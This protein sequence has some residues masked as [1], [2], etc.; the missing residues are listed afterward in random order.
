VPASV[1]TDPAWWAREKVSLYDCLPKVFAPSA[2]LAEQGVAVAQGGTFAYQLMPGEVIVVSVDDINVMP[3]AYDRTLVEDFM[4]A[5]EAST[6]G[7]AVDHWQRSWE[8]V[9]SGVFG[10]EDF[11][12]AA[13]GQQGLSTGAVRELI[14]GTIESGIAWFH[15]I[16][17]KQLGRH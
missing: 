5:P 12:A 2:L 14:L 9:D 13:L 3:Q 10:G 15:Q 6:T 17:C 8:L 7:K 11:C 1:S 16:L 4:R